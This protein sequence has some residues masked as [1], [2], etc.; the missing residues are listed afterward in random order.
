MIKRTF[1]FR[2]VTKMGMQKLFIELQCPPPPLPLLCLWTRGPPQ[3]LFVCLFVFASKLNLWNIKS[4]LTSILTLHK[5]TSKWQQKEPVS[6]K[7][8]QRIC[9]Q[10]FNY[11]SKRR[12]THTHT[13]T[14]THA[15]THTHTHTHTHFLISFVWFKH[16]K[17]F[18]IHVYSMTSGI[19]PNSIPTLIACLPWL[20][21]LEFFTSSPTFPI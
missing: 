11:D 2:P 15:R 6:P 20:P 14:H 18:H 9:Q 12:H 16:S 13:H 17:T 8:L 19:T 5:K 7:S 3:D 21:T 4:P 10:I 1:Y